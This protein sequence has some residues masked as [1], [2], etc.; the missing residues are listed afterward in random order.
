MY[1]HIERDTLQRIDTISD[2]KRTG[3]RELITDDYIYE[4]KR[5]AHPRLHSPIFGL[6]AG[7]IVSLQ[8][9][10]ESL[11]K[12]AKDMPRDAWIDL[13]KY[14][15]DGVEGVDRF[16][17]QPGMSEKN[18]T[19]DWYPVGTGPFMLSDNNPNSRMVLERNPNYHG[20]TYPC[21]GEPGDKDSGLLVDCGKSLPLIDKAVFSSEKE[22]IPYWNKFLQAYYDAFWNLVG[23]ARSGGAAQC[24][25]RRAVIRQDA[26]KGNSLAAQRARLDLL[27]GLQYA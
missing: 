2:F 26:R 11:R 27:H 25:R 14:D 21:A 5:L 3:T 12:E 9:L 7:R 15:L 4:I 17:S 19:L 1:A 8:A 13:D 23:Q 20:E 22:S 6:M 24:R 10:G 18:L 16:Y